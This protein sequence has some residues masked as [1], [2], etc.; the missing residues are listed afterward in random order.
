MHEVWLVVQGAGVV[1]AVAHGSKARVRALLCAGLDGHVA[2][3]GGR[4]PCFKYAG[5]LVVHTSNDVV[6]CT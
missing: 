4:G 1:L 3:L 6:S 2:L 5:A